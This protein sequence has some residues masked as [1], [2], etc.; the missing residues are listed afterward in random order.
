MNSNGFYTRR[1]ID[2]TE[3]HTNIEQ[4]LIQIT[5]DK[6]KL[7]LNEHVQNIEK[8]GQWVA[9]L[10]ILITLIIVFATTEFKA[11]YLTA[12][13]W[14]AIFIITT[15]LTVVWLIRSLY[16]LYQSESVSCLIG[17]IKQGK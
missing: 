1:T 4:R 8:K 13:T 11:A 6:L 15:L 14:K 3:V 2:V 10:G 5:E 12:D 9:P 7:I 16:L 17:K